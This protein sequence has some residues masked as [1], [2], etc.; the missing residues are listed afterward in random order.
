MQRALLSALLCLAL[1]GAAPPA[2][3]AFSATQTDIL[4]LRLG[5]PEPAVMEKLLW[6]GVAPGRIRRE[7]GAC[8]TPAACE[9]TLKVAA[10]DGALTID[11]RGDPLS[12]ERIT[13]RLH[14][15]AS[16]QPRMIEE[17]A[18]LH[19]GPPDQRQP[20]AWC[21]RP[22]SGG[23]CPDDQAALRFNRETL[24]IVLSAGAAG[25]RR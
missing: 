10:R 9:A 15:W 5:M 22:T 17:S 19:Y 20:M 23:A 24:T 2:G 25:P 4:G 6:Q 18:L 8:A 7:A 11:L 13:Y 14:G 12:V 1:N 21:Q 3:A 16:D